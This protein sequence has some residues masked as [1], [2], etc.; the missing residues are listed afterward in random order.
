M[1]EEQ[2]ANTASGTSA[3]TA[4]HGAAPK[5]SFWKSL[6]GVITAI[7]GLVVALSG[8]VAALTQ[9][10]W[11]GGGS[12]AADPPQETPAPAE[13]EAVESAEAPATPSAPA[14][15]AVEPVAIQPSPSV[16]AQV[17][18]AVLGNFRVG[19]VSDGWAAVRAEPTVSS[20]LLSRLETGTHVRCGLNVPDATGVADRYWRECPM[21][22]GYIASRLLRRVRD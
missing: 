16:P 13:L 8:L 4:A 1:R 17:G 19:P 2:G 6:P 12:P 7:T 5:G 10:G 20:T 11:L 14:A 18:A 15:V 9:T 3:A 21:V 22:G